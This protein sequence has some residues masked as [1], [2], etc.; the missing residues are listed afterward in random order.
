MLFA[1]VFRCSEESA[2]ICMLYSS[3]DK[4]FEFSLIKSF[5]FDKLVSISLLVFFA[6]EIVKKIEIAIRITRRATLNKKEMLRRLK[7][8]NRIMRASIL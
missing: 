2:R 4:L 7:T 1:V 5:S 3:V 8:M 6:K